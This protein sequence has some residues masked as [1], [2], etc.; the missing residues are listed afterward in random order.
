MKTS[1]ALRSRTKAI[2]ATLPLEA[3]FDRQHPWKTLIGLYR[4]DY[5]RLLLCLVFFLLKHSPVW[6]LPIYTAWMVDS[7]AS[8]GFSLNAALWP[9]LG[10]IFL[11]MQNLPGQTI[12]IRLLSVAVRSMEARVRMAQVRRL[13]QL[14]LNA[15][16]S[17]PSGALQ[18]KLMRDVENL[19]SLTTNLINNIFPALVTVAIAVVMTLRIS[20]LLTAFF[21][22]VAPLAMLLRNAFAKSF[23]RRNAAFRRV[24]EAMNSRVLEMIELLPVTRAHA[25]EEVEIERTGEGIEAVRRE[26]KRLDF[27]SAWF[28]ATAWVVFMTA[29]ILSLLL[30]AYLAWRGVMSVGQVLLFQS[31]FASVMGAMNGII[32]LMP[33]LAKGSESIRSMG[34]ILENPDMERNLG[35]PVISKVSGAFEFKNLSYRYPG[36]EREALRDISF[37]VPAGAVV[38]VTGESGS[39]KSTLVHLA[40]GFLR[41]DSGYI[42]LDGADMEGFDLRSYRQ[43][44]ATVPQHPLL[45]RGSVRDN[46]SYG[47]PDVPDSAV[48]ETLRMLG[49]EDFV[50][51]MPRGLD[52]EVGNAGAGLSGG[53]KQRIVMARA[54]L[55]DPRVLI[56]DEPTSALDPQSEREVRQAISLMAKGRTVFIVTHR[57][58]TIGDVDM[59]LRLC[60][61]EL[62]D[63]RAR[64]VREA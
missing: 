19:A 45:F 48:W 46:V 64:G 38:A 2:R 51:A 27:T 36:S 18:N 12:F 20:P 61:G 14:S 53:Q 58:E 25:L 32:N 8:G 22:V 5:W 29:Q 3:L 43:R 34:E 24:L 40:L 13:Q 17:W 26:G 11:V 33:E 62:L 54:L 7:L 1:P 15:Q 23:D 47:L 31:Y 28:G 56:L 9:S 57:P 41:P 52:T 30:M 6:V 16:G 59:E 60:R 55:R 44:V 35:K 63:I 39:G 10:M 49:A 21:L 37:S 50:R 42:L 4:G